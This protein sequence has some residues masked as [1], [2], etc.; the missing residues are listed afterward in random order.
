MLRDTNNIILK[1]TNGNLLSPF[2]IPKI[3]LTHSSNVFPPKPTG[4]VVDRFKVKSN[5]ATTNTIYI[6]FGDGSPIFS[7]DFT[8]DYQW[9]SYYNKIYSYPDTSEKTVKISFK[10]PSFI[11]IFE[12]TQCDFTKVFPSELG[13]YPNLQQIVINITKFDSLPTSNTPIIATILS[14]SNALKTTLTSI[15][16]WICQSKIRNLRFIGGADFSN[17]A[18]S[19]LDQ[20]YRI[21]DFYSFM[22]SGFTLTEA[23]FP[24]N[25]KNSTLK[26]LGLTNIA[27]S[28]FQKINDC[29]QLTH[30]SFGYSQNFDS[31]AGYGSNGV[32][33]SWGV[34]VG[35]MT[36]L[37][38]L[39]AN[40]CLS[41]PSSLPTGM[42]SSGL[43]TVEFR[44]SFPTEPR[45]TALINDAY[46]RVTAVAS[47]TTGNT[48]MRNVTF[49]LS[50]INTNPPY[51][52]TNQIRPTGTYQQPTGYIQGSNNG[53]PTS[54]MEK[55]WVLVKQ[56]GWK[57]SVIN[58]AANGIET[59]S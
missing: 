42:E 29:K 4:N 39:S 35:G 25:L 55:V 18:N 56:Y 26:Q 31:G 57:F 12:L 50:I 36:N 47:M 32:L 49:D 9:G 1:D 38:Y 7:E 53:S 5:S 2:E 48:T 51:P 30:I 15:P 41:M 40:F 17:I 21:T 33:S 19:N 46:S 10:F 44:N 22:A 54:P 28:I 37:I 43:K 52:L 34:G 59:L 11:Q 13:L 20:L 3:K 16:L 24:A 23:N 27:S 14:I 58:A 8:G 45:M 6:D